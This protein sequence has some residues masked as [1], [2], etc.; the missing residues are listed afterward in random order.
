VRKLVKAKADI[1]HAHTDEFQGKPGG[2]PLY[3]AVNLVNRDP[4]FI[5]I[6]EILLNAKADPNST[7]GLDDMDRDESTP[8]HLAAEGSSADVVALLL[9]AKAS[10]RRR[11]AKGRTALEIARPRSA[12]YAA[13]SADTRRTA[14]HPPLPEAGDYA[15]EDYH[16]APRICR[17][18]KAA[19]QVGIFSAV[20][21]E[22]RG[23]EDGLSSSASVSSSS[24]TQSAS[25]AAKSP[26]SESRPKAS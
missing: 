9:E 1:K 4:R 23:V 11:D 18:A 8:L 10:T 14:G 20:R 12:V 26:D 2:A 17:G 3:A 24:S 22:H 19:A 16:P 7:S 6:V 15:M 13:L 21:R 25:S 5:K